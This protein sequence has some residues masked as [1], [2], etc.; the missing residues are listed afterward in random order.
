MPN[1][2]P[3]LILSIPSG[4]ITATSLGVSGLAWHRSPGSG[5][6]FKGR[7]VF[8]L[9]ALKDG[10]PDFSYLDEGQWRDA[11][12]DTLSA[13]EKTEQGKRTKTA[14][15]NNAFAVTPIDAFKSVHLIKTGGEALTMENGVEVA[16]FENSGPVPDGMSPNEVARAA[17][18]IEPRERLPRLYLVIAPIEIVVLSTLT[19]Q[20]YAW[21]ATHRP[22]K[23]FRQ[24]VFT[25]IRA[26]QPQLA[27]EAVFDSAREEMLQ[28]TYKK[29]KTIVS[30]ECFNSIPFTSWVGYD[31][32][33][34]G[35]LYIGDARRL[36]LW[37][38][39]ERIPHAWTRALG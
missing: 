14:L 12:A 1:N 26:D 30:G 10:R 36:T 35:G 20:E 38:F 29:T 18:Q 33:E 15:S 11:M 2:E 3:Q 17:G 25:E 21:Y 19:P 6:Y 4:M 37:R 23:L 27:A 24:V 34:E 5:K 13:L 8:A 7:A 16:R 31:R 39:P 32:R 28:K 22:G 9:L